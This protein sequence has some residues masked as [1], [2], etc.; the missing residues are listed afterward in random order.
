MVSFDSKSALIVG[1][2]VLSLFGWGCN[3]FQAAQDKINEKIGETVTE[4]VLEKVTGG[5]V[6]V[7]N[8]GEEVTF[9][10]EKTGGSMSFGENVK[11]PDDFPKEALLYPGAAVKGVTMS[12]K[13]GTTSWV[14]LETA[15]DTTKVSDWYVKEAKDKGWTED[16]NMNFDGTVMRTWSKNDET[17][18][19][20][21]TVSAGT[22][23]QVGKFSIITT[24]TKEAAQEA[25]AAE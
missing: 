7:K 12:L 1:A 10:D 5:N 17:E 23:D 18:K 15:D 4:G 14:M 22:G 6:D 9:K 20:G 24:Y 3:P 19:I 21:L 13:E 2:A 25:P 11:L 16:S 8:G